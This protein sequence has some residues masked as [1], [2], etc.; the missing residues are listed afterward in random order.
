MATDDAAYADWMQNIMV[1]HARFELVLGDRSSLYER[2]QDWPST[3]YE[4]KGIAQG[5]AP[6]YL[7]YIKN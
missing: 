6:V 1:Q 2:P 5:R 3:R 4:Q 7:A